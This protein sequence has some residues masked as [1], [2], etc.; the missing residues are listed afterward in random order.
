MLHSA[1]QLDRMGEERDTQEEGMRKGKI[2]VQDGEVG[3]GFSNA[4]SHGLPAS[5]CFGLNLPVLVENSIKLVVWAERQGGFF[6]L[7]KSIFT[8]F[9]HPTY[10]GV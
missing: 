5:Q 3:G 2:Y 1:L 4:L 7:Q 8:F 10:T 9:L 6:K